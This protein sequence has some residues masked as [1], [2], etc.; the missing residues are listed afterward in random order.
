MTD[1]SQPKPQPQPQA[2]AEPTEALRGRTAIIVG[3]LPWACRRPKARRA[4]GCGRKAGRTTRMQTARNP[5]G[6]ASLSPTETYAPGMNGAQLPS[7]TPRPIL[8]PYYAS[9]EKPDFGGVFAQFP[10]GRPARRLHDSS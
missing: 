7:G 5:A 2:G 9:E 3:A 6:N 4:C 1:A 8:N 10:A